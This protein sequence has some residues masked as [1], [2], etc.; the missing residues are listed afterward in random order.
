M[1]KFIKTYAVIRTS[2]IQTSQLRIYDWEK[3][4]NIKPQICLVIGPKQSMIRWKN[5]WRGGNETMRVV[6]I[7]ISL[8]K[9]EK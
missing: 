1:K 5:K 4:D 3:E 9:L 8:S 6:P 2:A 7:E